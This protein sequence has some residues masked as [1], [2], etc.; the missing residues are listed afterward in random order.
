MRAGRRGGTNLG[1][2]PPHLRALPHRL[3]VCVGIRVLRAGTGR[4]LA[5]LTQRQVAVVLQDGGLGQAGG[6]RRVFR[7]LRGCVLG[8][9]EGKGRGCEGRQWCPFMPHS[10]LS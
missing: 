9:E 8:G 10:L 2:V 7:G 3:C 1:A 4:P 6:V 5:V